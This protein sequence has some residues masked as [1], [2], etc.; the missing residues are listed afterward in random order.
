LGLMTHFFSKG[1]LRHH[2]LVFKEQNTL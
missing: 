1:L 2:Y